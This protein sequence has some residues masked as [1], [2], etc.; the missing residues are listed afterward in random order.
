MA[1]V[2][3]IP[4][5][6]KINRFFD[7]RKR[8]G[9][10]RRL[11]RPIPVGASKFLALLILLYT[12][13][14]GVNFRVRPTVVFVGDSI[15]YNWSQNW[16]GQQSTFAQNNWLNVGVIGLT[17]SQIA[18]PFD[19]YVIDLQPQAVHI[20]AGT[21]DVYPGWQLSDTANN[22]QTMVKKAKQ[23]H[24]AVVIG[25]IPPWGPGALP[26]KADP[27][28][29]RFQ[30]IDQLNQ[31]IIQ[32]AAQQGIQV[33]DYHSLLAAANGENYVPALTV[34]GVHPSA[35]GYAVMTPYTEQALQAAMAPPAP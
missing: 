16:A 21:N 31:W 6:V 11:A 29:Q 32:F 8:V 2:A 17:S 1:L 19:S 28:P 4:G 33:V 30:R 35:A 7:I 10:L 18:A 26:E 14:C 9:P 27:S 20:L 22:I 23:H 5:A 15:T 34:D 13:G 12:S 25:T 3:P 24:I